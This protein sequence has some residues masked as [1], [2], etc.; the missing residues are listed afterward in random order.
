MHSEILT[1]KQKSVLPILKKYS[2]EFGLVGGTAVALH[3]GHRESIDFDLFSCREFE[4]SD[5]RKILSLSGEKIKRVI[6]DEKDEFTF[7]L[8]DVQMTFFHYPFRIEFEDDFDG[9]IKTPTLLTLAAMKAYVLGRRVKWKD[10]VDLYFILKDYHN[11]KEVSKKAREIFK[12]EFNEKIFREQL[13]YFE[14]IDYSE[15][16]IY[17]EGYKVSDGEVKKALVYFSLS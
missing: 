12:G 13:A 4:N 11:I 14:D 1:E 9:L 17:K 10:Y 3:I 8:K 2:E 15:E 6:R 5:I 7:I 16:V